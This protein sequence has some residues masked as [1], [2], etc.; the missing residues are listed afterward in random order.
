[1][2]SR[3]SRRKINENWASGPHRFWPKTETRSRWEI[4]ISGPVLSE[5]PEELLPS[6]PEVRLFVRRY[7]K[8]T[9]IPESVLEAIDKDQ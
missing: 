3:P 5:V 1:M 9:Y 6:R 2:P 4:F 7:R 8:Q